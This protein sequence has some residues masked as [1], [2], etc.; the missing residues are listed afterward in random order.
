M[1]DEETTT[2]AEND[3]SAKSA[4]ASM[5]EMR[6]N[7]SGLT[8]EAKILQEKITELTADNKSAGKRLQDITGENSEAKRKNDEMNLKIKKLE[9]QIETL[10]P[11]GTAEVDA[12]DVQIANTEGDRSNK[13]ISDKLIQISDENVELKDKFKKELD[14]LQSAHKVQLEAK[15]KEVFDQSLQARLIEN[16]VDPEYT[17]YVVGQL[18]DRMVKSDDGSKVFLDRD[19]KIVLKPGGHHGGIKEFAQLV[20]T[21]PSFKRFLTNHIKSPVTTGGKPS[22]P[23]D[24]RKGTDFVSKVLAEMKAEKKGN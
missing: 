5:G 18:A 16:G 2:T 21:E 11:K 10:S 23:L 7:N 22:A 20:S 3:A 6:D 8:K 1:T 4:K 24:L 9:A 12:A 14:D 19:S 15:D 17:G 13:A